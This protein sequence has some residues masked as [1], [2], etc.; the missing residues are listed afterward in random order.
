M[1]VPEEYRLAIELGERESDRYW[2][3]SNIMLLVQGALATVLSTQTHDVPIAVTIG[4]L[5]IFL[6]FL[7]LGILHKGKLYV[8]RWS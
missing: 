2:G 8:A 5:G 3:R 4:A 1:R 6:S 7:W